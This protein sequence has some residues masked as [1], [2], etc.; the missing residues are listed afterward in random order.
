M[1]LPTNRRKP[2]YFH[3]HCR[4]FDRIHEPTLLTHADN[5][6]LVQ[7]AETRYVPEL[8]A[9]ADYQEVESH[10]DTSTTHRPITRPHSTPTADIKLSNV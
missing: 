8:A 2:Q 7:Q 5:G 10:G 6:A 3:F 1:V 4:L 9:N